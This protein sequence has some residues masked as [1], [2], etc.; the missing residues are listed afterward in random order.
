MK[1][2]FLIE[3]YPNLE[4]ELLAEIERYSFL[5]SYAAQEYIIKQGQ[6]VKFLPIIQTGTVKVFSNEDALQFLL[7]YIQSGESCIYSFAHTFNTEPAEF[8]AIAESDSQLLL[9]PME[10]VNLWINKFPSLNVIILNNYRKHYNE[11]LSTTKQIIYYNLEDRLIDYLKTNSQR[12]EAN[13][14]EISHQDIANDLGTSREVITR[15]MKKLSLKN[16]VK[17]E[18]RKI[19]VL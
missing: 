11:L 13:L 15:L 8:S 18:G 16:I 7:Y 4:K 14:L 6:Y 1:I 2:D 17:Q 5:K 10:R 3:C 12:K 19:K 9:L